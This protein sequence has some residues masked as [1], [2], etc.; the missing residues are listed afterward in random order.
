MKTFSASYRPSA[1][2]EGEKASELKPALGKLWSFFTKTLK[3]S[4]AGENK[5]TTN[6]SLSDGKVVKG[7]T[8]VVASTS[9]KDEKKTRC[10]GTWLNRDPSTP[11]VGL[12]TFSVFWTQKC[13]KGSRRIIWKQI[14]IWC[15]NC[16]FSNTLVTEFCSSKHKQSLNSCVCVLIYVLYAQHVISH[17]LGSLIPN[18]VGWYQMLASWSANVTERHVC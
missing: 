17:P 16:K 1:T 13:T 10:S 15:F 6:T 2:F 3:Q 18:N 9:S 4:Q 7:V 12:N 11:S 8:A 5:P 14:G